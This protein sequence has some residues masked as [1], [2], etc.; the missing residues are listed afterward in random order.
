MEGQNDGIL[1]YK[2]RRMADYLINY[3]VTHLGASF[4]VHLQ[5]VRLDSVEK[6]GIINGRGGAWVL[7]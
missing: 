6:F 5:Y 2:V 4:V 7:L 1:I 3:S